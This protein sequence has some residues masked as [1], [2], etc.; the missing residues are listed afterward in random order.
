MVSMSDNSED[1]LLL[2]PMMPSISN[3]VK[4]LILD[5]H[6]TKAIVNFND[7]V[8]LKLQMSCVSSVNENHFSRYRIFMFVNGKP[9]LDALWTITTDWLGKED[10]MVHKRRGQMPQ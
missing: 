4:G 9:I 7:D 1:V 3:I 5:N 6:E 8:V 2:Q 10:P